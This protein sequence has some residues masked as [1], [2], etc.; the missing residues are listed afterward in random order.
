MAF[1]RRLLLAGATAAVAVAAVWLLP[2][3]HTWLKVDLC[4]DQGGRWDYPGHSCQLT[5]AGVA[6]RLVLRDSAAYLL[7]LQGRILRQVDSLRVPLAARAEANRLRIESGGHVTA[8][9]R[10]YAGP[11]D[12]FAVLVPSRSF[13]GEDPHVIAA[14][15][16]DGAPLTQTVLPSYGA[17]EVYCPASGRTHADA[18]SHD[19]TDGCRYFRMVA[20]RRVPKP[21]AAGDARPGILSFP[22]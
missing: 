6:D 21:V 10:W 14:F 15:G 17:V 7:G 9:V 4:L 20:P 3:A 12:Q 11:R 2:S 5:E 19:S 1:P 18:L 16:H 8:A 22:R 13:E